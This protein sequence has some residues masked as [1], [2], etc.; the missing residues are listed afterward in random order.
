MLVK[1]HFTYVTAAKKKLY[2]HKK[3]QKTNNFFVFNTYSR[4]FMALNLGKCY[5]KSC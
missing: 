3:K 5:T 4:D 1:I 2:N